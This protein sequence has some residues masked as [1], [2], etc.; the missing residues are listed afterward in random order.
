MKKIKRSHVSDTIR[1]EAVREYYETGVSQSFISRKYNLLSSSTFR[2]WLKRFPVTDE[3]LSLSSSA[4]GSVMKKQDSVLTQD[5]KDK[6]I[7]A[8]E[9]AL[10]H[11]KL[12]SEALNTLIDL[13]E[14]RENISIRKKAGARQ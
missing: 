14:K 13:A 12:R 2:F 6:R 4:I 9:K 5:E 10:A 7:R 8:L 1:L 11:E 3:S